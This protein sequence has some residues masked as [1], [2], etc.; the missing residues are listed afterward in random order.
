M[1]NIKINANNKQ[2]FILCTLFKNKDLQPT[3]SQGIISNVAK[4]NEKPILIQAS[5][6]IHN[7]SR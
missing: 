2:S 6:S 7:G 4:V 1:L 5:S 3:I